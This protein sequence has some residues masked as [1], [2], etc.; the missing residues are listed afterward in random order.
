MIEFKKDEEGV[1][2]AKPDGVLVIPV[3]CQ[4]IVEHTVVGTRFKREF[5]KTYA[6]YMV[7]AYEDKLRVGDCILLKERNHTV[8]LLVFSTAEFGMFKDRNDD[9]SAGFELAVDSLFDQTKDIKKY[10]SGVIKINNIGKT[11]MNKAKALD[12][13]WI[14]QKD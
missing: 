4:G 6:A 7:M 5:P 8:A 11:L 2:D 10:Y 3:N 9:V 1:L 13:K 12:I 14:I